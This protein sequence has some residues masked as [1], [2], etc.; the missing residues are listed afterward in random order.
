MEIL[1]LSK[2]HIGSSACVGGVVLTDNSFVRLMNGKNLYQ[3]GDTDFQIGQVWDIEFERHPDKAPHIEDV[4]IASKKFVRTIK[5]IKAFIKNNLT[6]WTGKPEIIFEESLGWTGNGSGYIN[7]NTL[8]SNSVGFWISDRDLY[9]QDNKYY[10]YKRTRIWKS[11]KFSYVGYPDRI[12]VIPSGTLMRVSL[13]KWW[14]PD[15]IEIEHRCYL[16]ISGWY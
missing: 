15:D 13:A 12:A 14:K 4:Y 6:I 2:T 11:R 9:L 16:Q 1:I 3:A 8:P 10:L 5:D 7:K